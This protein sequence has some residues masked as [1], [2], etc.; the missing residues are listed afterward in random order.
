MTSLLVLR[1]VIGGIVLL[2]V[3]S[4][5]VFGLLSLAPGSPERLLLGRRPPNPE[6]LAQVRR[7]NHL[8]E[9]FIAQYLHW[10]GGAVRFDFGRSIATQQP[11]S[12]MIGDRAGVSI[13][14]GLYGFIGTV[15]IGVLAGMVSALRDGTVLGRGISAVA[16]VGLCAPAFAVAVLLLYVFAVALGWFPS[17]GAGEGF[18]D[19]FYHLTLP[20]IVLIV[21]GAAYVV[22]FT[23]TGMLSALGQD[24]V[25][26]ARARGLPRRRVMFGHALRNALIPIVTTAGSLLPFMLTGAVIV[27][28]TFTLPGLGN[29]MII[30][31]KNHDIPLVQ[32]LAMLIA[33]AVVLGNLLTDLAYLVADPRIRFGAG[34]Q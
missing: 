24:Y 27:E 5:L 8:D 30:A 33:V 14:L 13:F 17:F 26:F 9:S 12:Q 4:L 15:V 6:V 29:L 16:F 20:A 1:R 22:Q 21:A 19:R 11:V 3:I 25:A 31:I 32:G 34:S 28:T 10:L 7:D 18:A 23:R 2:L